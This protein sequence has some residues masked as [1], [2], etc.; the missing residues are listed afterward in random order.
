MQSSNTEETEELGEWYVDIG[1]AYKK[2]GEFVY[3]RISKKSL[4]G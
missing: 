1:C 4:A 2:A 3:F